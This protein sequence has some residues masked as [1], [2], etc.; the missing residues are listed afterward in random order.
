MTD[1]QLVAVLLPPEDVE[2]LLA[3]YDNVP[4]STP[5]DRRVVSATRQALANPSVTVEGELKFEDVDVPSGYIAGYDGTMNDV[6][7]I[8]DEPLHDVLYELLGKPL[9]KVGP[10]LVTV[11][12]I[13]KDT[14]ND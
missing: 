13:K 8:G 14:P 3:I 7:F 1:Q 6:A 11:T 2:E 10:C 12:S 9:W 4:F 5:F